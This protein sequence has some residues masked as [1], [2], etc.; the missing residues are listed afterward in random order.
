MTE[1]TID[2]TEQT[3]TV[4]AEATVAPPLDWNDLKL[5]VSIIELAFERRAFG[6]L[7]EIH[8]ILQVRNRIQAVVEYNRPIMEAR[9]AEAEAQRQAEAQAVA[10]KTA[11]AETAAQAPKKSTKKPAKKA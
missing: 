3:T 4:A 8:A 1:Q 2:T 9:M 11:A 10:E 7:D 6:G 5:V